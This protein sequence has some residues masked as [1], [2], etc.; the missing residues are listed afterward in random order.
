[1]WWPSVAWDPLRFILRTLGLFIF[2]ILV[3]EQIPH[4][5]GMTSTL[6]C[7]V[8]LC[9]A[10]CYWHTVEILTINSTFNVVI[11]CR[12]CDAWSLVSFCSKNVAT[13]FSAQSQMASKTFHNWD[14]NGPLRKQLNTNKGAFWRCPMKWNGKNKQVYSVVC[15]R[16]GFIPDE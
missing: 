5:S 16:G 1:M 4:L 14:T 13:V 2:C 6:I 10:I 3:L 8:W 7:C 11:F 12:L 9:S 15:L